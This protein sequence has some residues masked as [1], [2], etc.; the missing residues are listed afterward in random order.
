M[1]KVSF[2]LV[3][4]ELTDEQKANRMPI[5]N[6][7]SEFVQVKPVFLDSVITGTQW[8]LVKHNY[9]TLPQFPESPD[10]TPTEFLFSRS[11]TAFKGQ[12]F[13]GIKT[14]LSAV[15]PF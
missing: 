13:D 8:C 14:I 5:A 12:R 1:R 9:A 2:K 3:S 6:E 11:R 15:K 7:L 4:K 10:L